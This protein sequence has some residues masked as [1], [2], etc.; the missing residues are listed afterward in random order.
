MVQRV[1]SLTSLDSRG[2][3]QG[4]SL[5]AAFFIIAAEALTRALNQLNKNSSYNGFT[6]SSKAR[7]RMIESDLLCKSSSVEQRK[8]AVS[9]VF[10]E[11]Y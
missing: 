7:K 5:S 3:K 8:I 9:L 2:V 6:I 11:K 10:C 1:T 4:D